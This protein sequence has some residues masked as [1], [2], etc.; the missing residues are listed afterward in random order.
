MAAATLRQLPRVAF[1]VPW[2]FRRRLI[3]ALLLV[4][5][6]FAVYRFWFRTSSFVAV[7]HVTVTGLTTADA[8]RIRTALIAAAHDMST[9]EVKQSVLDSAVSSFPVVRAVEARASFPHT[10][11][12]HVIEE[13]PTAVLLVGGQ[14]LLLAPDGSVLR[15]VV[16]GHP[17]P[18]IKSDGAV[19]QD[20]LTDRVPLGAL[21]VAAAAPAALLGR[22]TNITHG[23]E[24][25]LVHLRDGPELIFGDDKRPLAKWLAVAAVLADSSSRGASYVDVRIPGRPVAGGVDAQTLAPLTSNGNDASGESNTPQ[26]AGT[27]ATG[28]AD[29]T[30]ASAATTGSTNGSTTATSSP[31]AQTGNPQPSGGP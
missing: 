6:L 5:A 10:L 23:K 29:A 24:G 3:F 22:V 18:E 12:I 30:G 11:K 21:H 4:L 26:A 20:T 9:M 8:P 14:R 17:L 19:P 31:E 27:G 7:Q 25:I 15:G 2:R 13:K 1:A 28:D 16:T